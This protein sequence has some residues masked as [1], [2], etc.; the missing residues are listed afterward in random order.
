MLGEQATHAHLLLRPTSCAG[1]GGL[2]EQ[3]RF[4]ADKRPVK[5]HNVQLALGQFVRCGCSLDVSGCVPA[6]GARQPTA[7]ENWNWLGA[8]GG[9]WSEAS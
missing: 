2:F 7:G 9:I 6:A 1:T 8:L 5:L 4:P 3:A